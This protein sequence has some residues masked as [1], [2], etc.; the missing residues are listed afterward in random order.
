MNKLIKELRGPLHDEDRCE[1]VR[2]RAAA[3]I[4]RLERHNLEWECHRQGFIDI[5]KTAD[6]FEAERDALRDAL[7][8]LNL[9]CGKQTP[10]Q[11]WEHPCGKCPRC[12]AR[13]LLEPTDD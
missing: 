4:E 10:P 8:A 3:E 1:C 5:V 11:S 6:A 13:A 12:K 2:C 7:R 9:V